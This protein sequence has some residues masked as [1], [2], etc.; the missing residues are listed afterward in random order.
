MLGKIIHNLRSQPWFRQLGAFLNW[1]RAQLIASLPPRLRSFFDTRSSRLLTKL[2]EDEVVLWR[3]GSADASQPRELGRFRLEDDFDVARQAV[4]AAEADFDGE[5]P[6][7]CYLVNEAEVLVHQI[8]VPAAAEE[9]LRQVLAYEMDK[10]TPFSADQVYFDYRIVQRQGAQL[11][12]ELVAVPR[13]TLERT[14]KG[15]AERGVALHAVDV[16]LETTDD[17]GLALMGVNLLP[18]EHRAQVDRRQLKINLGLAALMIALLYGLMWQSLVTKQ[19]SIES[20]QARTNEARVEAQAVAELRSEL[21]EAREAASFLGERKATNPVVMNVL[22]SITRSMPDDVW[23]QRM[24]I[25]QGKIQLTG[26]ATEASA[27]ISLLG[28][29]PCLK[30]PA[31]KGAFTPDAKSGKERFT[32]EVFVECNGGDNGPA[33]AG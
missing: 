9:N 31:P 7:A 26:Q 25:T 15:L 29:D 17:D 30:E 12:V 22:Q 20:F 6:Q 21:S 4:Q 8:N 1:W 19:R 13:A 2:V 5:S 16:A 14:Q 32:I 33:A 28:E 24:Q 10:N 18:R 11:R 3:E 23:I 27:L